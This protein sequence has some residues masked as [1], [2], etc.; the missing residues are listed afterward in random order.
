MGVTYNSDQNLFVF[1]FEH[2]GQ[3]DIIQLTGSGYDVTAFSRCFYYGYEFSEEI[4]GLVRS[5]FIKYIKFTD[6]L[7]ENPEITHFIRKA[8]DDLSKKINLYDYDLVVMPESSSKVNQYMLRYIYRFAQPMLRQMELVKSLPANVSFDMDAYQETYLDAKLENGRP[9]YTEQQKEQVKESINAMM[10]L[11]HKKDYF[12]IAKDVKKNRM[13]PF[14]TDFLKFA[15]EKDELLCK[16]IRQQNVLVIDD[17]ATSGST[18]NEVLRALRILNE[19]NKITIFSLIG[20]KDLTI[21]SM[22]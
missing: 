13:R 21:E 1:D 10:D 6:N 20:R 4:D 11:I 12:T 14:I 15:N 8:I 9:R 18:L 2:D 3:N 17:I 5:A 7:K 22:D 16:T 19:D